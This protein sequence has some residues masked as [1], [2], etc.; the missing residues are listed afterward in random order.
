MHQYKCEYFDLEELFPPEL[1]SLPDEYLWELMDE[2][3][4]IVLD[5][6]RIAIGKPIIIN[7]WKTGG[8]YKWSGYRTN[9]CKI[10]AKKSLHR[11]GK[12]VDIK[13]KGMTPSDI[14][15]FIQKRYDEF[16]EIKRVEDVRSTPTWLHIDTKET[17]QKTLRIFKV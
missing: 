5:R 3:L 17:K 14:L 8:Q 11:V 12:A 2:N 6:L 13:I 1:M 15:D 10:G 16:P 9:S 7:N 4:L